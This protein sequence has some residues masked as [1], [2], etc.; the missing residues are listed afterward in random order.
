L[1]EQIPT[2][3]VIRGLLL[4]C[5]VGAKT[6]REKFEQGQLNLSDRPGGKA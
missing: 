1:S 3:K 6:W 5:E 4:G 2:G